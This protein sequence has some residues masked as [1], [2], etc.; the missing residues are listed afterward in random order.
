MVVVSIVESN[1]SY[2]YRDIDMYTLT[3]QVIKIC[4]I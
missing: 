4:M 1:D 3:Y 2:N